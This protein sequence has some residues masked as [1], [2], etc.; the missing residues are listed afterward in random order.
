[1]GLIRALSNHRRQESLTKLART[2]DRKTTRPAKPTRVYLRAR[3]GTILNGIIEVLADADRPMPPKEVHAAVEALLDAPV[4]W[5]SV[6]QALSGN[7]AG[8][9]GRSCFERIDRGQYRVLEP[10]VERT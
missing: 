4:R 5:G 10:M 6:K 2:L 3:P 7:L 1:M 9:G 8:K